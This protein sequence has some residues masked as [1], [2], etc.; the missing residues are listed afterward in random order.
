M[1]FRGLKREL[2]ATR[3]AREQAQQTI[4]MLEEKLARSDAGRLALEREL[5]SSRSEVAIGAGVFANLSSFGESLSGVRQ[6]FAGLANSLAGEKDAANE[7]ARQSGI[8]KESFEGIAGNLRSM[9]GKIQQAS[10][11]VDSLHQ[12]TGQIGGIVQLIKAIADQTN[13]LALNA[14]IEAARAG[15][16]GRGFA[17]VADEVRKL[18]ERTTQAT[19]EIAGLVGAIQEETRSAK[20]IMDDGA[21]SAG[22]CSSDA[23]SATRA[24]GELLA[25]AQDMAHTAAASSLLSNVEHANIEEL[26]LK[27][28]VYKV[29]MGQSPIRPED[30]PDE[31]QCRLG[32]WYYSD[33]AKANLSRL[34]GYREIED[35]HRA[36]HVQARLA[37]A[38]YREGRLDDALV[39]LR[40]M[41]AANLTVMNGVE[42]ILEGTRNQA[43]GHIDSR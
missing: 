1:F 27:L 4:A 8:N 6:S 43:R 16:A 33:E 26:Q 13:L 29:F 34:P 28:E 3:V 31:T 17:V 25:L 9:F 7:A 35:P 22:R 40:A 39:A 32:Q 5:A 30:L 42:R 10:G 37:V 36:V 2:T 15:E 20:L 41:E 11:S 21:D 18:A 19:A 23:E 12:R 24:M 14:A 38:L